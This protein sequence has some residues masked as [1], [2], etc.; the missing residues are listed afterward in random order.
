MSALL[1]M[2]RSLPG[3]Q[4]AEQI[5]DFLAKGPQDWPAIRRYLYVVYCSES[6]P[7]TTREHLAALAGAGRIECRGGLYR[8]AARNRVC[9]MIE[10]TP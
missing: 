5:V 7:K 2:G 8:L 4:E 10:A 9:E 3:D 1:S 6:R